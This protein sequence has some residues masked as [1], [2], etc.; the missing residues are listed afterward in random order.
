MRA[1]RLCADRCAGMPLVVSVVGL[2]VGRQLAAPLALPAV[3]PLQ[4]PCQPHVPAGRWRCQRRA[5]RTAPVP[6]SVYDLSFLVSTAE[7][8]LRASAAKC[9][10]EMPSGAPRVVRTA[11]YYKGVGGRGY[12]AVLVCALWSWCTVHAPARLHACSTARAGRVALR[13]QMGKKTKNSST[14]LY[15]PLSSPATTLAPQHRPQ[16]TPC[17]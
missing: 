3:R 4:A 5:V 14:L 12:S 10:C 1:F 11:R 13:R 17:R 6:E 9:V 2:V 7:Y 15:R 8:D 16:Y